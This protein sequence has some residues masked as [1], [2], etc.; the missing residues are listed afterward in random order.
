MQRGKLAGVTPHVLRHT[1]GVKMAAAGV[2]MHKISQFMGHSNKV[3]TERVYARFAPEHLSE[4][5]AALEVGPLRLVKQARPAGTHLVKERPR[6]RF[7]N[8]Y[9]AVYG[10]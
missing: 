5:V 8:D 3:V 10:G 1:P 4:A 7:F 2:P 9:R 6:N